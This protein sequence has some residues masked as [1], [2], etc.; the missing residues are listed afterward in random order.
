M[1]KPPRLPLDPFQNLPWPVELPFS[2]PDSLVILCIGNP[3]DSALSALLSESHCQQLVL[4][5]TNVSLNI[6]HSSLPP[7][8]YVRILKT[9]APLNVH[10]AGAVRLAALLEGA[11]ALSRSWRASTSPPPFLELQENSKGGFDNLPPTPPSSKSKRRNSLLP[12]STSIHSHSA[13]YRATLNNRPFDAIVNFMPS[14]AEVPSEKA[15]L[16]NAIL[17]TTISQP[18]LAPV[19]NLTPPVPSFMSQSPNRPSSRASLTPSTLSVGSTGSKS[20]VNTTG[21]RLSKMF[22]RPG[23]GWPATTSASAPQ[24]PLNQSR[25]SLPYI[26][27]HPRA[28]S[29]SSIRNVNP[30]LQSLTSVGQKAHIIHVIPTPVYSKR[31]CTSIEQFLMSFSFS[32]TMSPGK[33]RLMSAPV[34]CNS[35]RLCFTGMGSSSH[36]NQKPVSYLVPST[37]LPALPSSPS[38]VQCPSIIQLVLGGSLDPT[39]KQDNTAHPHPMRTWISSAEDIMI[40]TADSEPRFMAEPRPPPP[41]FDERARAISGPTFSS[42]PNMGEHV[43][44]PSPRQVRRLSQSLRR[45][46]LENSMVISQEPKLKAV[47]KALPKSPPPAWNHPKNGIGLPTPPDSDDGTIS[48]A[49]TISSP[50]TDPGVVASSMSSR[51]QKRRSVFGLFGGGK[52]DLPSQASTPGAS[53]NTTPTASPKR[54]RK[55]PSWLH[56]G[57]VR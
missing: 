16:K 11:V 39:P 6:D 26:N 53:Q 24:T 17:V 45:T 56:F 29:S 41:V 33:L 30:F 4:I 20:S 37:L 47:D 9:K 38:S 13:S 42:S 22:N 43:V 5:A 15:L 8:C 46:S 32:N 21:S 35:T 18:F 14:L 55:A 50:Q 34:R 7:N 57:K 49:S 40:V 54:L 48:L 31:I 23:Q 1:F 44:A 19:S 51:S 27:H 25:D 36:T 10:D 52:R 3:T 28:S 2:I 12:S